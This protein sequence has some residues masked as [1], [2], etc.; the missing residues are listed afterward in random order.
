MR[1]ITCGI[2]LLGILLLP[3]CVTNGDGRSGD[4]M[5]RAGFVKT[6]PTQ[7][8]KPNA[9]GPGTHMNQFGGAVRTV[10]AY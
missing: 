8:I 3:G 4:S 5:E 1:K 7:Y 6:G 10:P 9:Y 2:I